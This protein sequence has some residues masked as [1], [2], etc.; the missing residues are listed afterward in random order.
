[1]T[2]TP[3]A[4][5]RAA[6]KLATRDALIA[7]GI[8]ELTEHGPSGP[9]LDAICARAGY[10]R[11]AFYVHFKDREALMIAVMDRMLGDLVRAVGAA[12]AGGAAGQPATDDPLAAGIRHFTAAAAARAPEVHAGRGLRFHHLLEAC[13]MSPAIGDRYKAILRAAGAWASHAVGEHQRAGRIPACG[14]DAAGDVLL[15]TGLGIVVMLELG[16]PVDPVRLGDALIA[17]LGLPPA[18]PAG[19]RRIRRRRGRT[20]A[21]ERRQR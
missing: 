17:L 2:A 9:S 12:G 8:A 19:D 13:L 4:G 14:R 6:G 10:T 5:T 21:V 16:I 3:T 7:A 1:M 18:T 15:A 11:G 20:G